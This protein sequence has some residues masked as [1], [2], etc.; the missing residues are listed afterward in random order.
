[1]SMA[2]IYFFHLVFV[3]LNCDLLV[4]SMILT[5]S[6]YILLT[7]FNVVSI[8]CVFLVVSMMSKIIIHL[9]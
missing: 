2:S 8:S 6:R 1:M 4:I 3:V 5:V 7:I 9:I